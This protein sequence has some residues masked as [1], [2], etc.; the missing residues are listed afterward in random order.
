RAPSGDGPALSVSL[1]FPHG[2]AV[3]QNGVLY[4]ADTFN[5]KI[6]RLDPDGIVRTVAG[7]GKQEFVGDDGPAAKAGLG[8]P[9]SL[10]IDNLG[11]IYIAD[12]GN[13]RVRKI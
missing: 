7:T 6:R 2:V 13:W 9:D 11:N 3:D 8:V 12:R 5:N 4:V 10:A 1:S